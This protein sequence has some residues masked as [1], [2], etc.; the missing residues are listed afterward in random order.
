MGLDSTLIHGRAGRWRALTGKRNSP[1]IGSNAPADRA[2]V[3][4]TPAGSSATVDVDCRASAASSCNSL[5]AWTWC[6]SGRPSPWKRTRASAFSVDRSSSLSSSRRS[7][8]QALLA[9]LPDWRSAA[10]SAAWR[11]RS[12]WISR[13]SGIR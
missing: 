3:A 9:G 8:C 1:D 12:T 5:Q 13:C 11:S 7:A 4:G 6:S 10:L 2:T